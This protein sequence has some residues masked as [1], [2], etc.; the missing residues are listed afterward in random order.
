MVLLKNDG[1][2]LPFKSA[3]KTI[4]VIGPNAESLV[5]LEGNYN[6][7]PSHPVLP[8]DGIR[9]QFAGKAEVL[10]AQGSAYVAELPVPVPSTVFH[11]GENA[12]GEATRGLQGEYFATNGFLRALR[13]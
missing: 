12:P 6:G 11:S 13:P 1:A 3:V 2:T 10:Y 5:A 8:V 7:V 9:R 4:A